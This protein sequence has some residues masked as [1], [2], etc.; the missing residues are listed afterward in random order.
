MTRRGAMHGLTDFHDI[1]KV[2]A[3]RPRGAMCPECKLN[4]RQMG[5]SLRDLP[6]DG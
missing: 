2:T 6:T 1:S 5:N 3:D 4:T